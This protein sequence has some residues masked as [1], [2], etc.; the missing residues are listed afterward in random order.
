MLNS[1]LISLRSFF[2]FSLFYGTPFHISRNTVWETLFW[3]TGTRVSQPEGFCGWSTKL[4]PSFAVEVRNAWSKTS[5]IHH[6]PSRRGVPKHR[7]YFI[8][9]P[10]PKFS[11][12]SFWQ[13]DTLTPYIYVTS[14]THGITDAYRSAVAAAVLIQRLTPQWRW[15]EM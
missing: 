4:T 14:Q 13:F 11:A 9:P 5:T 8:H 3:I 2:F 15:G 1:N 10:L 12:P 6:M 7:D